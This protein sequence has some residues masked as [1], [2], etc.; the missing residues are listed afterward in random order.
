MTRIVD[1]AALCYYCYAFMPCGRCKGG[2]VVLR[3][4]MCNVWIVAFF[5]GLQRAAVQTELLKVVLSITLSLRCRLASNCPNCRPYC[6]QEDLSFRQALAADWDGMMS[7]LLVYAEARLVVQVS[8]LLQYSP[9]RRYSA[10][11]ALT[12]PFFDELRDQSVTLPNGMALCFHLSSNS[13]HTRYAISLLL[14]V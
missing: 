8:R 9:V 12:H 14:G 5:S 10:L 6:G 13:M 3:N 1:Y 7:G 11:Q 2:L 4:S